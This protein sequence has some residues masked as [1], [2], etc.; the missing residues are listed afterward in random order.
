MWRGES[1]AHW[2]E[3][4]RTL[5]SNAC[6]HNPPPSSMMRVL[7][8]KTRGSDKTPAST[9]SMR[10]RTIPHK[11]KGKRP[12]VSRLLCTIHLCFGHA[13]HKT[14]C[15]TC[16]KCQTT[17]TEVGDRHISALMQDCRSLC[18][19]AHSYICA[20]YWTE[21]HVRIHQINR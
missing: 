10:R 6:Q 9:T 15:W 3:Q 14:R 8:G 19:T 2:Q 21:Q 20:W 18:R 4:G 17:D 11:V 1:N 7:E 16:I 13:P 5:L 12:I